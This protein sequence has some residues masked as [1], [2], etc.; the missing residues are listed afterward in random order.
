MQQLKVIK[1]ADVHTEIVPKRLSRTPLKMD[2]LADRAYTDTRGFYSK[3]WVH[4]S[5]VEH[6]G[7]VNAMLEMLDNLRAN[8][9]KTIDRASEMP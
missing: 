1:K 7:A 3:A 2:S 9:L 4:T 5:R 6:P 8:L